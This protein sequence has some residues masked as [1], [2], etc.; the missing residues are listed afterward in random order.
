MAYLTVNDSGLLYFGR[1]NA[2]LAGQPAVTFKLPADYTCPQ[3]RICRSRFD[4]V[5]QKVVD[6][7]HSELRCFAASL[8]AAFPSVRVSADRNLYLLNRDKSVERMTDLISMSLPPK[9]FTI[10]RIH[11][12]GDFFSEGYMAA[13]MEVARREPGRLFYAYTKSLDHWIKLR[14]LMPPNMTLVASWGGDLDH[15][16]EPHG[17][18]NARVIYHPEE[19]AKWGDLPID[20]DDK[21]AQDENVQEF[22]ILLHG[23]QK[24][25][26]EAAKALS[27][28]KRENVRFGYSR[29]KN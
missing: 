23:V 2:K 12:G 6:G 7:P 21:L 10:V 20:H 19:A 17:L 9:Y 22:S 11:D 3:A 16:I 24:K 25:G 4:R 18:R 29:I 15:L 14:N 5:K 28:M 13:W 27:R 1:D 8:E 26:S